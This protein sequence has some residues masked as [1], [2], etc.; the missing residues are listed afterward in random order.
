MLPTEVANERLASLHNVV[1]F[2]YTDHMIYTGPEFNAMGQLR[3]HLQG[4]RQVRAAPYDKLEQHFF[5]EEPDKTPSV[6]EVIKR[7]S[8]LDA[9]G[10]KAL[11]A[12]CPVIAFEQG[13]EQMSF[14]PSGWIICDQTVGGC[15]VVGLRT[16]AVEKNALGPFQA[17]LTS[18]IAN[19]SLEHVG[20]Q[21]MA[22]DFMKFIDTGIV[23]QNTGK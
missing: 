19:P 6:P 12:K 22:T 18:I 23:P 14:V 21:Q 20:F 5:S 4:R 8:D 15:V 13:P 7:F 11:S 1:H 9:D 3:Y 16:M 17:H 10:L 2:G